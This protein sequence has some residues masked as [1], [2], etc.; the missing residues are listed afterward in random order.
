MVL[1]CCTCEKVEGE[2][3]LI[4]KPAIVLLDV[5]NSYQRIC[6]SCFQ[7]N[8][9]I[10]NKIRV[11]KNYV[12]HDVYRATCSGNEDLLSL[13]IEK[14]PESPNQCVRYVDAQTGNTCLHVCAQECYWN[15]AR[16]VIIKHGCKIDAIN[17]KGETPLYVACST[18]F[19]LDMVTLLLEHGANPNFLKVGDPTVWR[20]NPNNTNSPFHPI[21]G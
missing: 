7:K 14:L 11:E 6:Q 20:V 4:Q 17:K 9:E 13:V 12:L 1:I 19:R 15:I 18:H 2:V 8:E 21:V 3:N 10:V 5:L 16:R